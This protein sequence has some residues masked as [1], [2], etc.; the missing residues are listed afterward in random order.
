[1]KLAILPPPDAS[2]NAAG[3]CPT[4]TTK[5]VEALRPLPPSNTN[6]VPITIIG[7]GAISIKRFGLS[8]G[9]G[10]EPA[11]SQAMSWGVNCGVDDLIPLNDN[12]NI[13]QSEVRLDARFDRRSR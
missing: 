2:S 1:M 9:L 7:Q 13:P 5:L 10:T 12:I 4:R 8:L 3:R 6:L 11:P